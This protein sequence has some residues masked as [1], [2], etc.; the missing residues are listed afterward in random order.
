MFKLPAE[1][2]NLIFELALTGKPND[3]NEVT[4]TRR[5]YRKS[6]A[7]SNSLGLVVSFTEKLLVRED[8]WRPTQFQTHTPLAPLRFASRSHVHLLEYSEECSADLDVS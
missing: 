8:F 1:L 5:I 7:Y 2:R 4:L 3:H 6:L